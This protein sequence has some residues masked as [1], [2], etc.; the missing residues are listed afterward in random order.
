LK[1]TLLRL[2][3]DGSLGIF[4][5]PVDSQGIFQ[6]AEALYAQGDFELALVQYHRG[7]NC[8]PEVI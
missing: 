7:H 1:N 3:I 2:G 6:K 4:A 5:I 8:R